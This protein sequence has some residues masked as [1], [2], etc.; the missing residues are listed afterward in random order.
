M[1]SSYWVIM[2]FNINTPD[3]TTIVAYSFQALIVIALIWVVILVVDY[4]RKGHN[5]SPNATSDS[6]SKFK[7]ALKIVGAII[8]IIF[9]VTFA[10]IV[11]VYFI[12]QKVFSGLGS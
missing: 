3:I 7:N 8:L 9:L 4:F 12:F 11:T 2:T 1:L 6:Y 5:V 10:F